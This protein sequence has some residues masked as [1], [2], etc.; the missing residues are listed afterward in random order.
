MLDHIQ[1]VS[2]S[3]VCEVDNIPWKDKYP[4]I[5]LDVK[6]VEIVWEGNRKKIIIK[7]K[8]GKKFTGEIPDGLIGMFQPKQKIK[9]WY[10]FGLLN[11]IKVLC[12]EE[13]K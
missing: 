13:I 2:T 9:L 3:N 4:S 8:D 12:I 5:I 7:T 10:D 1:K 11:N 6:T